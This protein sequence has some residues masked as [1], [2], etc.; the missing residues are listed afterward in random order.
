M[1]I[2]N[3]DNTDEDNKDNEDLLWFHHKWPV[4]AHDHD[5][6]DDGIDDHDDHEDHDEDG[7]A[8]VSA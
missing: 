6:D 5:D 8:L 7:N 4:H 2:Y 1:Q 3:K